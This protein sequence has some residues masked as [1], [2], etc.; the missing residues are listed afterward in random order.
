MIGKTLLRL[1]VPLALSTLLGACTQKNTSDEQAQAAAASANVDL[2]IDR[3]LLFP[4][5]IGMDPLAQGGGTFETNT[6][7]YAAAYYRAIDPS[8]AKDTIDKWRAQNGFTGYANPARLGTEH[9]ASGQAKAWGA[10]WTPAAAGTYRVK[11][12]VKALNAD[13]SVECTVTVT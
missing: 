7:E 6:S 9:L 11:G 13:M 3:F 10:T 8:D 2:G 12:A 4:N 1:V 5:P